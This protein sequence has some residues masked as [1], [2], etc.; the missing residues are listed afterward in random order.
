MKLLRLYK[1]VIVF[2]KSLYF[3]FHYLPLRQAIKL[4]ILVFNSKLMCMKGKVIIDTPNLKTGLVM[5]G[6]WGVYIYPNT[7]FVW[8]NRG[9]TVIFKGKCRIG[10]SSA[11]SVGPFGKIVFGDDFS[12]THGLKI[13]SS[14]YIE[15]GKSVKLGWNNLIIDT[16]MHPTKDYITR[17][18]NDAG[19]SILIGD[20]NWFGTDCV[21]LPGVKTPERIIC[22]LGSIITKS[23][24]WESYS[25][26]GGLPLHKLK[27][28][29]Y[30]DLEDDKD[31][32]IY[33]NQ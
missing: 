17:K 18:K 14:R 23:I 12:N 3:N 4:P 31:E 9:G 29:I 7:G 1:L 8:E 15:F 26:Y 19:A 20:Y 21:V 13:I 28:N 5:I 33:I 24:K 32:Y 27:D 16:N 10:A 11:I 2:C 6:D 25:L 22:A 30:R